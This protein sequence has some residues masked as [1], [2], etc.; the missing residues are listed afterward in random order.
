M[1]GICTF[2]S[3]YAVE[4]VDID[5]LFI[6]GDSSGNVAFECTLKC[7]T[8]NYANY[9]ALHA[10]AGH[11]EKTY[12]LNGKCD[13][14]SPLGT[15]GT[16]VLNGN[17]YTNCYIESISAASVARSRPQARVWDFTISFVRHTTS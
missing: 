17:S 4:V 10:L 12:A 7:R 5:P 16:L 1:A 2:G 11:C 15:A 6:L 9:T 3:T 14:Y 8:Q 13:V